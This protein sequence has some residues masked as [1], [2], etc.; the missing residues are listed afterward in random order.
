MLTSKTLSWSKPPKR[1]RLSAAARFLIKSNT[2]STRML[3]RH[4]QNSAKAAMVTMI[5]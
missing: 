1:N 5:S 4:R 2:L 3:Y